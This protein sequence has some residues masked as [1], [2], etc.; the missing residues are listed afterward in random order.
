MDEQTLR[1]YLQSVQNSCQD[2]SP[3]AVMSSYNATTVTRNG[4]KLWDYLAQPANGNI[5]TDLL[6]SNWGFDGFVTGDCGAIGCLNGEAFKRSLFPDAEKLSDVPQ[7]ATVAKAIQAGN[8]L[9]CGNVS[10]KYAMEAVELGYLS[11]DE[12]E[13]ALYRVFLQRFKTGEFDN[14]DVYRNY[15]E[16]ND[17]ETDENVAVALE[18][19]EKGIVMLQNT[20]DENGE[21]LLPL[22]NDGDLTS[23]YRRDGF[24]DIYRRLFGNADQKRIALRRS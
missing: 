11:E 15:T 1:D 17:L 6:R 9:D 20:E 7:S 4:E 5:L 8:E 21:T 19:A 2:A 3:G 18:A 16:E 12:I 14:T 23:L 13:R 24:S 10:T 22:N